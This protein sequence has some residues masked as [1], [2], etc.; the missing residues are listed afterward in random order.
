MDLLSGYGASSSDD[1]EKA[2]PQQQPINPQ[3]QQLHQQQQGPIKLPP[4]NFSDEESM[5]DT[6]INPLKRSFKDVSGSTLVGSANKGAAKS[7]KPSSLKA[8]ATQQNTASVQARASSNPNLLLPPQ[9][10]GRPNVAT[11]DV[12]KLFTHSNLEA[13]RSSRAQQHKQ[14]A[15]MVEGGVASAGSQGAS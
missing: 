14:Q 4:P 13:M 7:Q 9:L 12:G 3:Q 11:E 10:K 6:T 2:Q 1:E 15:A 8:T 5:E